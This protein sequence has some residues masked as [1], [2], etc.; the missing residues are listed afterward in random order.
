MATI[1]KADMTP[2]ISDTPIL[3]SK[4]VEPSTAPKLVGS[5]TRAD[6]AAIRGH[7]RGKVT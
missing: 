6:G 2:K 5:P 4:E 7:T 3:E 1:S